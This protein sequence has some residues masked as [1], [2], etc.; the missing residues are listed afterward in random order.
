ML[1]KIENERKRR[2]RRTKV[3]CNTQAERGQYLGTKNRYEMSKIELKTRK[4][5]RRIFGGISL[6]AIAFIFHAC[7][8]TPYDFG[9]DIKVTGTVKSK[10]THLP[11][12]GIK[13]SR[14]N[15]STHGIT[16]KNG[17]FSF[18]T[19]INDGRY[20]NDSTYL[21]EDGIPILFA[22]IDGIE[23]G[24]FADT[25]ILISPAHKQEVRINVELREKQ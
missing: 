25:T 1:E 16:D 12:K 22:D 24:H 20:V 2:A 8:G 7:Y 6:T 5:L 19:F 23:N 9:Y 10:T 3:S 21:P 15:S 13:V 14:Q 18:Y 17:N 11:I 4:L